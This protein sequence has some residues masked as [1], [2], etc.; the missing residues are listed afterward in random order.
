MPTVFL[1]H[2]NDKDLPAATTILPGVSLKAY[3]DGSASQQM[4]EQLLKPASGENDP[5]AATQPDNSAG[6][7]DA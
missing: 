3:A 1:N 2:P 4:I 5:L 6:A 7:P